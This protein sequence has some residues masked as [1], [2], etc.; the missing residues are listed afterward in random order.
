MWCRACLPPRIAWSG[1]EI[2][3]DAQIIQR[4]AEGVKRGEPARDP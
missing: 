2:I 4:I 3:E 1:R